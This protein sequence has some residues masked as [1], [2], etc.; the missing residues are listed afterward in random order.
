MFPLHVCT[1][2]RVC[3]ALGC[4]GTTP[5]RSAVV[6][7]KCHILK[8]WGSYLNMA[9]R[10]V[11]VPLTGYLWFEYGVPPTAD[12]SEYLTPRWWC[13]F[14][15]LWSFGTEDMAGR[16]GLWVTGQG[17]QLPSAGTLYFPIQQDGRVST[18]HSHHS[19]S[20]PSQHAFPS[21]TDCVP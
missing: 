18:T 16:V 13:C 1:C 15:R 7:S 10:A 11:A 12:V 9:L 14:R 8:F 5:P 21:M 6:F 19:P 2:T 17:L 3:L 4:L 20:L